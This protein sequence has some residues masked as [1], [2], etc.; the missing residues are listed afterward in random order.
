MLKVLKGFLTL[1]LLIAFLFN[2]GFVVFAIR[3]EGMFPPDKIERLDLKKKGLKIKPSEIY[4]PAGGGLSEAVVRL[5]IGC[6]GEFVS[7]KGLILTNHHCVFDALVSASSAEKNYGKDGFKA[8]SMAEEIPAKGYSVFV[9]TRVE[10]VTARVLVGTE[11]LKGEEKQKVIESNIEKIR[12]EEQGKNLAEGVSIRIQS[13]NSGLFYYLYET[14]Q[15]K[16]VRLVYAPPKNIGFFGGDPDNFEWTRHTGDF[17]F[18]RAYVSPDGKPAEYSPNN[19]PYQ[20]KKY[21]TISLDGIKENDFVFVLGYPGSTTRYRESWAIEYA[22]KVNLPFLVNYLKA[23]VNGLNKVGEESEEKRIKLQSDVF[24]LNNSI[25]AFEGG[26]VTLRRAGVVAKRRAEEEKLSKWINSDPSRQAK[27]GQLLSDLQKLSEEFYRTGARDRLL[28]TIP[29]QASTPIFSMILEAIS[30]VSENKKLDERKKKEIESLFETAEPIVEQEVIRFYLKSIA[31]L[32]SDQKFETAEKLFGKGNL[33]ERRLQESAFAEMIT[34]EFSSPEKVI[35]IYSMSLDE[36]RTKY[37]ILTEFSLGLIEE[38]KA[39]RK[40]QDKF[41]SQIDDLRVAYQKA[42]SEMKGIEPYPDANST[43][44][45]TYGYVKG[46][47]PKEAVTYMPFTTLKGMIEKDTGIEPFDMPE[48]L[49]RLQQQKDFGRYGVGDSVPLNFLATLDIIGGN[50]GSPVLNAEGEQIGIIFDGNYEGLGN[51]FYYDPAY[52]RA[53]A[54]DIRF[55][56][57]V[58]EKFANAGWILNEMTIKQ[59]RAAGAS[60]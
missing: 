44:R 33:K 42:M 25:K 20:P 6:T 51:D 60:K 12:K 5:S 29:N 40:R 2:G 3:D 55:V 49:K 28:R 27:Y 50:S 18:L 13:I 23:W 36:L 48:G 37:P 52:N 31:D 56:L 24:S 10:D 4:N 58:T 15:I 21:L 38:R 30:A 26:I 41:S 32:P 59:R 43:L 35:A 54:V 47:Q 1:S 46:Y 9:T 57:F 22:E 17:G 7:P 8:N 14:F 11:G 19:V 53:I 34:K 16:D 39:I 45:F